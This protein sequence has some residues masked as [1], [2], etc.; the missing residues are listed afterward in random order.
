[1]N[2]IEPDKPDIPNK[3]NVDLQLVTECIKRPDGSI[4]FYNS[5]VIT[6]PE[7]VNL[8]QRIIDPQVSPFPSPP[9]TNRLEA[10]KRTKIETSA[11]NVAS[12]SVSGNYFSFYKNS[13]VKSDLN[14]MV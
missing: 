12:A 2:I 13:H 3:P 14:R 6:S 8:N 7:I 9:T 4:S 11:P 1:M 10:A 5:R